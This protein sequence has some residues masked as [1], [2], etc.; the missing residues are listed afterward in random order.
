MKSHI[1]L[2]WFKKEVERPKFYSI[3]LPLS[4]VPW[5]Y[6]AEIPSS[7]E[8]QELCDHI[9]SSFQKGFLLRGCSAELASC[10]S[11]KG[12]ETIRTGAEGIVDLEDLN[13]LS[14]SLTELA[15][16]GSKSG[17]VKE[18]PLTE[19]NRQRV[20]S[21]IHQTQYALKPHLQ[22]LFNTSFDS[23]TRCFVFCTSKDDWLG[24]IT[25]S[26][27]GINSCHTEMILR[28]KKASVGVMESLLYSVM[29]IF[30]DEG[31]K[32]FSLGEVPFVTPKEMKKTN[33]DTNSLQENLLFKS[34]HILR[35]AFNY[36]G[37]F[38][39]KNKFNPKW[40]PVYICAT[41]KLPFLSLIDLFYKT[42][43]FRLSRK[44]LLCNI[45]SF[46]EVLNIT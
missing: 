18:I 44:E 13:K 23:N 41:P 42:G 27:S 16:R 14:K 25:I 10:L 38:D 26:I 20:S 31:Y 19:I 15:T 1:P 39:F 7:Y 32:H 9:E 17:S 5:I 30:K 22:Y 36:K 33:I 24:V 21:F 4:G 12:Y 2:S 45:R 40:E 37:L 28:N 35:Y 43:Y 29:N 3:D 8:L 6:N 34:G 11:S 46:S